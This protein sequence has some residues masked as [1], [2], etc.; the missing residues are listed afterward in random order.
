MPYKSYVANYPSSSWEQSYGGFGH[1][2]R[3]DENTV[4]T[5][6]SLYL[7]LCA[8]HKWID[9]VHIIATESGAC[10]VNKVLHFID[11]YGTTLQNGNFDSEWDFFLLKSSP[12]PF[13]EPNELS[14]LIQ[15][16][17]YITPVLPA[18]SGIMWW[19]PQ[20]ALPSIYD[21]QKHYDKPGRK[22]FVVEFSGPHVIS[23]SSAGFDC[24]KIPFS[25]DQVDNFK[26]RIISLIPETP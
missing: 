20:W 25:S 18:P 19:L 16:V 5:G 9:Q 26:A 11:N 14:E 10:V 22:C 3:L 1:L 13:P 6:K 24:E 23:Q 12:M 7:D 8:N 15:S 2:R 4:A 17:T 21:H